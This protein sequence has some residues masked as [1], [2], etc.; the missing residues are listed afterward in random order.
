M[1]LLFAAV[2]TGLEGDSCQGRKADGIQ[3]AEALRGLE[4]G[5]SPGSGTRKWWAPG[6]EGRRPGQGTSGPFQEGMCRQEALQGEALSSG[7]AP[8]LL[9]LLFFF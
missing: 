2:L 9:N 3:D 8:L 7:D 4:R 1:E 5:A 6:M